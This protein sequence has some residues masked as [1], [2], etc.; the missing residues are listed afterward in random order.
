MSRNIHCCAI[1]EK[2]ELRRYWT[3]TSLK[4]SW[5]NS[6]LGISTADA[7][8]LFRSPTLFSFVENSTLLSL[9]L[10]PLSV[11]SFPQPVSHDSGISNITGVPGFAFTASRNGRS[12]PPC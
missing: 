1:R 8:V 2:W 7:K 9:G 12:W 5:A 10:V 6:K 11:S 3:K 4:T